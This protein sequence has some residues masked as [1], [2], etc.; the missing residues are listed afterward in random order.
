MVAVEA[1]A[2]LLAWLGASLLV[3]ADGRRGLA[4]GLALL[5]AGFA[6]L[7]LAGGLQLGAAVVAAGGGIAAWQCWRSPAANWGIMP[8]GSTPRLVLC[9]GSG[10][11]G[12]WIAAVVTLGPGSALR[13]AI[14]VVLGLMGARVLSSSEL[15]VV[16]AGIAGLAL[17]LGAAPGLD[18]LSDG[19][20]PDVAGGLIAAGV[21]ALPR[22]AHVHSGA[23]EPD[24][25]AT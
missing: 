12:L 13:F 5:T 14:L 3:L 25:R 10:L 1:A 9:I 7:A 15:H 8:A 18:L 19:T 20:V 4:L 6:V 2:A 17:A 11:L 24:K 16:L 22:S 23:A 21:M